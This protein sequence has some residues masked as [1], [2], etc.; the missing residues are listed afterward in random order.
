MHEKNAKIFKDMQLLVET[1]L[2][3]TVGYVDVSDEEGELLKETFDIEH[4]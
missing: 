1:G 3:F 2:N 4:S